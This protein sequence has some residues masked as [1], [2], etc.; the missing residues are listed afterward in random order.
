VHPRVFTGTFESTLMVHF[1]LIEAAFT[2]Y[3]ALM[4]AEKLCQLREKDSNVQNMQLLRLVRAQHANH[5]RHGEQQ[6][7]GIQRQQ[8]FCSRG[9]AS[10]TRSNKLTPVD[11]VKL[12]LDVPA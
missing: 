12:R 5:S 10:V 8:E 3:D 6:V 11:E 1:D 9:G 4:T 2:T 7:Y